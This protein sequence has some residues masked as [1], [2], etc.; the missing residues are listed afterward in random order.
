MIVSLR[1]VLKLVIINNPLEKKDDTY[2]QVDDSN[3]PLRELADQII[4]NAVRNGRQ[5]DD[6]VEPIYRIIN[7]AQYLEFLKKS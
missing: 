2:K 7:P 6:A 5:G 4:I 3:L 1:E